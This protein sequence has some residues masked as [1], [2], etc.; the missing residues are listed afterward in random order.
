MEKWL[1]RADPPSPDFKARM[2]EVLN[3]FWELAT[4]ANLK[5]GFAIE[6]RLAPVEFLFVGACLPC[7]SPLHPFSPYSRCSLLCR[8][9]PGVLLFVLHDA[10]PAV[11]AHGI[12]NLRTRIREQFRDIRANTVVCKALWA[13]VDAERAHPSSAR[14]DM[15]AA[16]N[17][18]AGRGPGKRRRKGADG[19]GSDGEYRPTPVKSLGSAVKTRSKVP[20]V[21]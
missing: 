12:Y 5:Y 19:D 18:A 14:A 7:I 15:G 9:A 16:A 2:N 17:G 8:G 20:K 3:G 10:S 21:M 13:L 6:N 1:L 11:R 4:D